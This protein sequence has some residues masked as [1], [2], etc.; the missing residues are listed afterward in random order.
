MGTPL[1]DLYTRF[2]VKLDENLVE[3]E[4]LIFSLVDVAIAKS[5]K[6][7]INSLSYTLDNPDL[8]DDYN[9]YQGSFDK[10]LD[11]DEVEL[12]SLHMLYEWNRRKQQYLLGQREYIGT[13]D[14][15]RLPS[16]KEQLQS[17]LSVMKMINDDIITAQN[18]LYEYKGSR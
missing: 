18:N 2:Q 11:I 13:S 16:K 17:V 4:S 7:C 1:S 10:V 15:N 5:N 9:D 3:K 8:E 12:L 6:H 14:F